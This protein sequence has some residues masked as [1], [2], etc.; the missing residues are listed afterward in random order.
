VDKAVDNFEKLFDGQQS[1]FL[2]I[3]T[4]KKGLRSIQT[5]RAKI[6]GPIQT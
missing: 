5:Y 4:W 1:D 6:L 3:L 2:Q